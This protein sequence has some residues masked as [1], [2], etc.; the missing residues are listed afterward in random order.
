MRTKVQRVQQRQNKPKKKIKEERKQ[1]QYV[2]KGKDLT[3]V[4]NSFVASHITQ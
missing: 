1:R 2:L 4:G 3:T